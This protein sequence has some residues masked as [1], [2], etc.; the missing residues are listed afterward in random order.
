MH[1]RFLR[2]R[3]SCG[4]GARLLL[5]ACAALAA[6]CA[7]LQNALEPPQVRLVGLTL[8][9][10]SAANQRFELALDVRNPHPIPFPGEELAVSVRLGGA[11]LL[12]GRSLEPFVLP[13]REAE[14]VRIE[15]ESDIVSSLSRLLSLAQGPNSALA[16][17]LNGR[18][19][20]SRR[21]S[22]PIPFSTR[23]EVPLAVPGSR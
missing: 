10:A 8:V 19:T 5:V 15:V 23:G 13:A 9:E 21:L 1:T 11:G 20:P 16:Y 6:G 12:D 18:V 3:E 17:E 14:T 22:G 4:R 2:H 7:T